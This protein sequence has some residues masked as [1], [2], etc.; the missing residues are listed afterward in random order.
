MLSSAGDKLGSVQS[1]AIGGLLVGLGAVLGLVPRA[2]WPV[3]PEPGITFGTL[4]TSPERLRF[5]VE[6]AGL[7]TAAAGSVLLVLADLTRWWLTVA[8]VG[9]ASLLIW[10]I[11]AHKLRQFWMMRTR[12]ATD[13]PN[14]SP[15]V[16]SAEQQREYAFARTR[17]SWCLRHAFASDDP[18]PPSAAQSQCEE[19]PRAAFPPLSS[20]RPFEAEQLERRHISDLH[21]QDA[22]LADLAIPASIRADL[23][24]MSEQG[25][26][27]HVNGDSVIVIAQD[28]RTA[29]AV[30]STLNDNSVT[31]VAARELFLRQCEEIGVKLRVG[32]RGQPHAAGGGE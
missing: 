1:T 20:V 25:F 28:G 31:T 23:A 3:R 27:V 12:T 15:P 11:A 6:T 13:D 29:L 10:T 2:L 24:A 17:W 7:A 21:A 26:K 14:S 16:A 30:R 18:W 22:R 4:S 5:A 19:L 9:T 8:I 32:A